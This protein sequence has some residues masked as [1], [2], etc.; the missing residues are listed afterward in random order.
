MESEH[1]DTQGCVQDG[2]KETKTQDSLVHWLT[3][4]LHQHSDGRWRRVELCHLVFV[5]NLPH[6]AH[7]WVDGQA[8][9]LTHTHTHTFQ[10]PLVLHYIDLS[11]LF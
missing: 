10:F 11:D 4:V 9:K 2:Y 1:G 3:A 6:A 5:Y 8:L 7:V